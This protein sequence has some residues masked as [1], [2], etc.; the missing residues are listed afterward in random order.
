MLRLKV[1]TNESAGGRRFLEFGDYCR[2]GETSVRQST[3]E[4]AGRMLLGLPLELPQIRRALRISDS[5]ARGR[6]DLVQA[7]NHKESQDYT[8]STERA[9]S[10]FR[11]QFDFSFA[12][13]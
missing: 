11:S 8:G 7:G 10:Q 1:G 5:T 12:A 9:P 6:N 4:P 13:P 3:P 2:S